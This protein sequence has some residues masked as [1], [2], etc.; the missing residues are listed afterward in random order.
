MSDFNKSTLPVIQLLGV[1]L[2][3]ILTTGCQHLVFFPDITENNASPKI[4]AETKTLDLHE[5]QLSDDQ[6]LVGTI[7]AVNT[8][9]N[10]TLSDIARHLAWAITILAKPILV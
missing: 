5:F 8:R 6:N 1:I 3:S 10:D 7:A 9:E 2:L 4:H